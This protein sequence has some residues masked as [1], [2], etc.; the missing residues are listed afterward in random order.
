M[1]PRRDRQREDKAQ[2]RERKREA[3]R[4]ELLARWLERAGISADD[5]RAHGGTPLTEPVL[6]MEGVHRGPYFLFDHAGRAVGGIRRAETRPP[7][8]RERFEVIGLEDETGSVAIQI[9]QRH[10]H[11]PDVI[12]A[13]DG[14]PLL[15]LH[16]AEPSAEAIAPRP[17][18]FRSN[19]LGFASRTLLDGQRP[20]G[21]L[22]LP[23]GRR[24][25]PVR[26]I[27]DAHGADVARITRTLGGSGPSGTKRAFVIDIQDGT[28]ERLRAAALFAGLLWDWNIISWEAGG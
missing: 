23:P 16:R 4:T 14:T 20:V 9:G 8:C 15:C 21:T 25:G 24:W 13:A 7:G 5:S 26:V 11:D 19:S 1:S 28:E 3:R 17:R 2:A 22:H 6:V 10:G 18:V 27:T 12:S